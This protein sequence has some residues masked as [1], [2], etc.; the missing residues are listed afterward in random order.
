MKMDN[1]WWLEDEIDDDENEEEDLH[2]IRIATVL[3]HLSRVPPTS[4]LDLGCGTG[5]LLEQVVKSMHVTRVLGIDVCAKSVAEARERLSD[6]RLEDR[7]LNIE[8]QL[9]SFTEKSEALKGFDAA[10]LLETIEHI[11]PR[12]LSK[13][14]VTLFSWARPSRIFITTPNCEYNPVFGQSSETKRRSDHQF[15][16]S[17]S[18][19]RSWAQGV[20]RRNGYAVAIS[21]I[22]PVHSLLG[23]PSQ[24]AEFTLT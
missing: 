8:L 9:A 20:A 5:V 4:V 17:R 3:E 7:E 2:S 15:E 13:L 11:D 1:E 14:E 6:I 23:S 18:K 21:G 16:W 10:V 24:M 22:G 12:E 19:F